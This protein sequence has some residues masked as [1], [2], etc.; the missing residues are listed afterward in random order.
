HPATLVARRPAAQLHQRDVPARQEGRRAPDPPGRDAGA[1]QR[2]LR[3]NAEND[4]E[5]ARRV[6]PFSPS[7]RPPVLAT[8]AFMAMPPVLLS[9]LAR[10]APG[11]V[12]VSAAGTAEV[13]T[14][15]SLAARAAAIA[16]GI[17]GLAGLG[18]PAVAFLVEP[19]ARF[20][21]TLLGIWGAGGLAV[22]LSP[23]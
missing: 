14:Y 5:A 17:G 13:A 11:A 22:P 4:R 1:R 16:A 9:R 7:Q 10:H 19:G 21:E 8:S 12:A 23:L 15:E 20:V 6:A 18:G 3:G 2:R